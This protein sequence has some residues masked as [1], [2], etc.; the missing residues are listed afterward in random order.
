ME[1]DLGEDGLLHGPM[2]GTVACRMR[3]VRACTRFNREER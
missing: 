2:S 3:R 1:E